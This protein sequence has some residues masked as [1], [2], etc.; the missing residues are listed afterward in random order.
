MYALC[1]RESEYWLSD[2]SVV[3]DGFSC[4]WYEHQSI[5]TIRS[6]RF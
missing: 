3:N 5:I 6:S 2:L 4:Q 1:E